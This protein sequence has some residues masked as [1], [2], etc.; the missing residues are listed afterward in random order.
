MKVMFDN[1]SETEHI[2]KGSCKESDDYYKKIRQTIEKDGILVDFIMSSKNTC[3]MIKTLVTIFPKTNR[4]DFELV[5]EWNLHIGNYIER[6]Q[7][8]KYIAGKAYD[9]IGYGHKISDPDL[10]FNMDIVKNLSRDVLILSSSKSQL[11]GIF[12][13]DSRTK[14]FKIV[15]EKWL[16]ENSSPT[17]YMLSGYKMLPGTNSFPFYTNLEE[18][19]ELYE[20]FYNVKW[21]DDNNA[22]QQY[23]FNVEKEVKNI[24]TQ[25][26]KWSNKTGLTKFVVGISGGIDS[27]CVATLGCKIFGSENIIGVSLPCN[28]QKDMSDVDKVFE[29]LKIQ[30]LTIDIGDAFN[31]IVS[32]ISNIGINPSSDTTTNLPAR[33]RMSTLY[34]VSQSIPKSTVVNTCNLSEDIMGWNTFGGDNIGSFA[35][36][37]FLT[38]TEV[39]LIAEY[40][41][42]PQELVKKTPI[43]GLQPQTDEEK[44][45]F[46]YEELDNF[47]RTGNK[48]FKHIEKVREMFKKNKFKLEIVSI[49]GVSNL[50][51][52]FVV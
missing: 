20:T 37:R 52:N 14:H 34:A 28:G 47:I 11:F 41:G 22:V 21:I 33:L 38:K 12:I 51:P 29:H 27:T 39:R 16:E 42:V 36:V 1:S 48:D 17:A 43:D 24:E 3:G 8:I 23:S 6:H 46:S 50:H 19:K 4:D 45:G 9:S 2:Y 44:F 15:N 25:W 31:S 32:N 5:H 40:L 18:M 10:M 7:V 30:R 26:K 13:Y 35:P 49:P